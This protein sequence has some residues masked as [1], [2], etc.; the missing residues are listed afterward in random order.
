MWIEASWQDVSYDLGD[1]PILGV[2]FDDVTGDLF[3]ATDFGVAL[4]PGGTTHWKPAAGS[5]P[6]AAVYGLAIHTE[7]RV[8][9]AATHGRGIWRLDLSK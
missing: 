9:Y 4:L 6:P 1:L 3:A 7:G 2:A 8:L 5:L